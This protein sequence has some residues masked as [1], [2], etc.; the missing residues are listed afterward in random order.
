MP[1]LFSRERSFFARNSRK[2]GEKK[3]N[4]GAPRQNAEGPRGQSG[5]C[6]RKG[7]PMVRCRGVLCTGEPCKMLNA[8]FPR[9]PRGFFLETYF[10]RPFYWQVSA[11][12]LKQSIFAR[13]PRGFHSALFFNNRSVI[14][15]ISWEKDKTL[16]NCGCRAVFIAFFRGVFS[17]V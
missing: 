4:G 7:L 1:R 13:L 17:S 9:L 14:K 2:E 12:I 5:I 3:S 8:L 11:Q 15:R 6:R 10:G 16:L